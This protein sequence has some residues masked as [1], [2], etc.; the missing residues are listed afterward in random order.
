MNVSVFN[1][2]IR[3]GDKIAYPSWIYGEGTIMR[4]ATVKKITAYLT[5]KG[6]TRCLVSVEAA[7]RDRYRYA[8]RV[9]LRNLNTIVKL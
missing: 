3:P 4:K 5:H 2:E 6:E 7:P 8:S 9:V 1:G